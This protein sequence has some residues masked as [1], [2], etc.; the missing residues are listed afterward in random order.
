[1]YYTPLPMQYLVQNNDNFIMRT[2]LEGLYLHMKVSRHLTLTITPSP[3]PSHPHHHTPTLTITPLPSLSHPTLT[4]LTSTSHLHSHPLHVTLA[5][6]LQLHHLLMFACET[7]STPAV[8]W[9]CIA[10]PWL[11][12]IKSSLHPLPSPPLPSPP[13]PSPSIPLPSPLLPSHPPSIPLPSPPLPS[14]PLPFPPLPIQD[15]IQQQDT[16]FGADCSDLP[17]EGERTAGQNESN[18]GKKCQHLVTLSH[19]Q[20][21]YSSSTTTPLAP[22]PALLLRLLRWQTTGAHMCLWALSKLHRRNWSNSN[23]EERCSCVEWKW[24]VTVRVWV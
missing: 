5:H 23:S 8:A 1:M 14:P 10:F 21:I 2:Q 19:T 13:F 9:L 22:P 24:G 4:H 20:L 3:S 15:V 18:T 17:A 11:M 16:G 6:A 12:M 7:R